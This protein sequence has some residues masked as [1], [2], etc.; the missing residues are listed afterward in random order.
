M[1]EFLLRIGVELDWRDIVADTERAKQM[2]QFN[3]QDSDSSAV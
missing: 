2:K 3:S 1:D